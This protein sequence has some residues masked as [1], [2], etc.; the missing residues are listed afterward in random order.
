MSHYELLFK[1]FIDLIVV[2]FPSNFLRFL[3]IYNITSLNYNAKL[4]LK[5][6]IPTNLLI[7]TVTDLFP[8]S[9]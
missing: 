5:V 3:S 9:S 8:C 1:F 6:F 2:D 7:T 4:L